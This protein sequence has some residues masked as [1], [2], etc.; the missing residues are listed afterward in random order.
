MDATVGYVAIRYGVWEVGA[1][2]T[3]AESPLRLRA[4]RKLVLANIGVLFHGL[5]T[6]S[7][8]RLSYA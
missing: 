5:R 6:V 8:V 4:S 2:R 7:T 3:V 1:V